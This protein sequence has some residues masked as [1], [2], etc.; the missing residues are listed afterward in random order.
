MLGSEV[1]WFIGRLVCL[2]YGVPTHFG[3]CKAELNHFNKSLKNLHKHEYSFFYTQLNIKNV[4]FQA[5]QLSIST[6][7]KCQKQFYFNNSV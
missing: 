6:L 3:P 5:I 4:L 7:F 1:G 2:F